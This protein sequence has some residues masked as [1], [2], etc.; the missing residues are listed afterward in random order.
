MQPEIID[1][2]QHGDQETSADD[3]FQ[4]T[5]FQFQILAN[6]QILVDSEHRKEEIAH[7]AGVVEYGA[8]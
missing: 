2:D 8:Q 6:E 7:I 4:P 3:Q 5:D 1:G